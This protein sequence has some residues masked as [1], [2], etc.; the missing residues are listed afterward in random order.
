MISHSTC[1]SFRTLG[2]EKTEVQYTKIFLEDEDYMSLMFARLHQVQIY[3]Y[4]GMHVFIEGPMVTCSTTP[5]ERNIIQQFEGVKLIDIGNVDAT[6]DIEFFTQKLDIIKAYK[7]KNST[8]KKAIEE[9]V[10]KVNS[11]IAE[12][13][14]SS[15]YCSLASY[16]TS[17]TLIK[18]IAQCLKTE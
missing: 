4:M 7:Y 15:L 14:S 6:F 11:Y 5:D 8:E 3:D 12:L 13:Q 10:A 18:Q 16:V 9:L 2:E 17:D 1:R